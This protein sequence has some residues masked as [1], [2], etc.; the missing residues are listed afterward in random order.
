MSATAGALTA[1]VADIEAVPSR[2]EPRSPVAT[3]GD[4]AAWIAALRRRDGAAIVRLHE[5][6]VRAARFEVSRRRASL[7]FVRC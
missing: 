5:L 7:A 1:S 4:D 6:L 3:A 2:I